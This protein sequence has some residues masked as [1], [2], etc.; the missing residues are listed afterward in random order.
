MT[1]ESREI[2][3]RV[4]RQLHEHGQNRVLEWLDELD[5]AAR[6]RLMQQLAELDFERLARL[7]ELI[8]VPPTDIGFLDVS[9]APIERIPLRADQRE[10]ERRIEQLGQQAL[11]ADRVAA[12]TVAGGQGTR[13]QYDHP[14]GMYPVTPIRKQSLFELFA[15][16]IL[17]ARRRYGCALPWLIMTS[18][19][20]DAE[21]RQFFETNGFFHL[22]PDCV[23]FF[24]QQTNPIL[25]GGGRLLLAGEDEL[26]VGPDGHGG[27]FAALATSGLLEVLR[28]G[29]WDIISYFQVDNPLVT[30]ADRRFIGHHLHKGADFSCKVVPKRDPDEGLGLV[31]MKGDRPAIIEYTDVPEDVA[32]TRLPS[33]QLYLRYGSIAVNIIDVPF[34]ERVAQQEDS[35]PWH[36]ARKQ[37]EVIGG[38][39]GKV[40]MPLESCYKFERFIFDALSLADEC[41]FVEVRR[42]DDFAP[43]KNAE[44]TD[45]PGTARELMQRRWL[46]WLQAA[47]VAVNVPTN[48]DSPVVEI[49]PL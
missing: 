18:P 16:Q 23:H 46:H 11:E 42:D 1:T 6:V 8:G 32:E 49:S 17:A 34:C 19:T 27:A 14:K 37:Y 35:L 39:G 43:V 30:V 13:L 24:V 38:N 25:D 48:L 41:A 20:N 22:G 9:P 26:L 28:K 40:R 15:E 44:G 33:G 29:G 21:T 31:V 10:A 3:R 12:L 45:S 5:D 47:G 2:D 36:V 4:L 7:R